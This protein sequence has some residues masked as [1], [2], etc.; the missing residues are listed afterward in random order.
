MI[1]N[2]LEDDEMLLFYSQALL[3]NNICWK[4]CPP[5]RRIKY[6]RINNMATSMKQVVGI[7][8]SETK[9]RLESAPVPK[10]ADKQVLIKVV[11]SGSNPKDWKLPAWGATD[12]E[13]INNGDDIAGIVEEVGKD[14]IAFKVRR[15]CVGYWR[16]FV[17]DGETERRPCCSV[18]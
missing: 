9:C 13:P 17:A 11:V 18:P 5:P 2:P 16:L 4:S 3:Y 15:A 12:A 6:Q 7:P 10:P 14:V 8:G 1:A